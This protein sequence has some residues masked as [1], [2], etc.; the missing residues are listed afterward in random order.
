MCLMQVCSMW[1][2]YYYHFM[3]FCL[4]LCSNVNQC[5]AISTLPPSPFCECIIEQCHPSHWNCAVLNVLII[6]IVLLSWAW[7][8]SVLRLTCMSLPSQHHSGVQLAWSS[9][10]YLSL[11]PGGGT[12]LRH[13]L[14]FCR[15][16]GSLWPHQCCCILCLGLPVFACISQLQG[17]MVS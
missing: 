16:W 1:F 13:V 11:F 12:V 15:H 10:W 7:W 17:E 8:S 14:R 5:T 6:I 2:H 3:W 9:E 4:F